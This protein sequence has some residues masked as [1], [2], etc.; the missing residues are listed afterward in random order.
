MS[1]RQFTQ[2]GGS[3]EIVT[4]DNINEYDDL[5][6]LAEI[7]SPDVYEIRTGELGTDYLVPMQDG[8][9]DFNEWYSLVDGEIILNIPDSGDLRARYDATEISVSDG[10]SISTWQDETSNSYDLTGGS[11][12]YKTDVKN[13]NSVVRF[14]RSANDDLDIGWGTLSQPW[15]VAFV[16][17]LNISEGGNQYFWSLDSGDLVGFYYNGTEWRLYA[18][19]GFGVDDSVDSDFHVFTMTYDGGNSVVRIDGSS[20]SGDVGSRDMSGFNLGSRGDRDEDYLDGDIGEVLFYNQ[21]K[22]NIHQDI[23]QYLA[24]KWGITI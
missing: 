15:T 9:T 17:Q 3:G 23:E 14:D 5:P 24:N 11:P 4:L 8:S 13:G 2:F 10:D 1:S 7:D 16:G 22:S 6:P 12:I 21:D 18:G 20:F 19:E